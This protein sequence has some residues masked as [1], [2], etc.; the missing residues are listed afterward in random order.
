MDDA[1][2]VRVLQAAADL[3]GDVGCPHRV[4]RAT[5]DD[6]EER[7]ADEELHDEVE[8][9]LTGTPEVMDGDDIRMLNQTGGSRLVHEA[10]D[11]ARVV[12]LGV[13]D[14]FDRDEPIH[15]ELARGVHAA[16]FLLRRVVGG[17]HIDGRVF[18][19]SA[20]T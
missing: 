3:H 16:P 10:S 15:H 17:R 18:D 2:P 19:R 8:H 13:S 4:E 20:R 6:V 1:L 9:A 7:L 11:R 14:D 5:S 12:G